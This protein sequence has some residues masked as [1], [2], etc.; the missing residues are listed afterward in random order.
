MVRSDCSGSFNANLILIACSNICELQFALLVS[1]VGLDR[2][3]PHIIEASKLRELMK[4]HKKVRHIKSSAANFDRPG[5]F[6]VF[7][8]IEIAGINEVPGN[9]ASD[10]PLCRHYRVRSQIREIGG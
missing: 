7:K 9:F 4:C 8:P 10:M 6:P 5:N 2:I 1:D 3:D